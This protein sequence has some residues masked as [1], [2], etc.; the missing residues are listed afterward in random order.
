LT[1][2]QETNGFYVHQIHLFQIQSY[3]L[4]T[5]IDLGSHLLNLLSSES[6]TQTNPRSPLGGT[7]FDLHRHQFLFVSKRI[8]AD[9]LAGPLLSY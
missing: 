1:C 4:I 8:L 9:A 2:V 3:W 6:A 5:T 7:P